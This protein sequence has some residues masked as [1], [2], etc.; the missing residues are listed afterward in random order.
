MEPFTSPTHN[1]PEYTVSEI[2]RELKRSIE[3]KYGYVRIRGEISG[4][5]RAASGH[6]Y[7]KLKDQDATLDAV[8]WRGI[9]ATIPFKPEDGLEVICTGRLT[10]YAARSNYQLV[11]ERMEPSGIGAL[12]ALLEKRK[13]L[14][15]K[16]GLFDTQH[17]KSLP[18]F[19]RCIGVVTSPTGAVIRDI[20]HRLSERFPCHVLVWPV[21]VQGDMAAEQISYAITHF[22]HITPRPDVII[23]ARGG[24]SIEDLWPF[25]EEN[26][27]RATF[28]ATIPVISAVG[29]ETDTTLIDY[30]SD[31]RAPT[32]TAA[33]EK[34]VPDTKELL[35][36]LDSVQLRLIRRIH[37]LLEQAARYV[38]SIQRGLLSPR[39]LIESKTQ[40]LDMTY[41]KLIQLLPRL[42][43]HK[44][45]QLLQLSS[46]LQHPKDLLR[47]K[48]QQLDYAS[49]RLTKAILGV[50]DVHVQQCNFVFSRYQS[51]PM[52]SRLDHWQDRLHQLQRLL[53]SMHYKHILKRG[54]AIIRDMDERVVSSVDTLA[55]C[56]HA[57]VELAD[58]TI[59]I[60]TEN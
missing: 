14:F 22:H 7:L 8:C 15:E 10:T 12:M 47:H 13:K 3:E 28:A 36:R 25:N 57:S 38:G 11:I 20:L 26:V 48:Q 27:V 52:T 37:D 44:Q 23:V 2:S 40:Q 18:A 5:T 46:Q 33:A 35:Q 39:S 54:F 43:L 41:D 59:Q 30:V 34:A 58:G 55:K 49:Q 31:L 6:M 9:A 4:L 60:R 51:L 42:H 24:G 1:Q 29:H 32:P 16:E 56:K 19:P 21:L 17:K 53:D 45:Q 50:L